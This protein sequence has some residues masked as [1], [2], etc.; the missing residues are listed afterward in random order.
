MRT[1]R[2]RRAIF[3]LALIVLYIATG[4][5]RDDESSVVLYVSADENIA[6]QVIDAFE[7]ETG[8]NVL[9]VGDTEVKKTAGLV[10]RLRAEKNHPRADVFW[11]SEIFMTIDLAKEGM[12]ETYTSSATADWP[13]AYCD[14]QHRWH[15]FALRARVIVYAPDRIKSDELPKTWMDLTQDRFKGRIVMA[16]PRFGT[17]GGHLGVMKAYW[18]HEVMPG[19]FAAYVEG[20][21]E[22]K[23]RLLPGGNAGVVEA[24]AKGEADLG[25]TDSDDVWAA[26][27]QGLNVKLIYP[28]HNVAVDEPGVGTLV[29]PNTV[30]RLKDSPH[31]DLAKR[32]V[33]FLLSEKIER[34][35]AESDAHNIPVRSALAAHYSQ[36]AAPNPLKIDY[37]KAADMRTT[38]VRLF[39][40]K[41]QAGA[42]S[43]P[44]QARPAE[45]MPASTRSDDRPRAEAN[46]NA[47]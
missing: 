7:K 39:V 17:T 44:A 24:V 40:W 34:M 3:F 14:P 15:G 41:L 28:A 37:A 6:R 31:P 45:T 19:Y 27:A 9:M 42:Q 16:D 2:G 26:Q 1:G 8:I 25:M 43:E 35:M 30:A 4:C 47:G 10:E 5:R 23:V 29:I 21:A 46:P 32:L 11:S 22:N 12:F 13:A 38:A 18:D 20:L 33:D 36:Y